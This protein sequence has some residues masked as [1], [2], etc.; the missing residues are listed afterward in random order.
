VSRSLPEFG[1]DQ[2]HFAP[3]IL[4]ESDEDD[5]RILKELHGDPRI[6]VIDRLAQQR[7][8]LARLHPAPATDLTDEP[9]RWA[10]YPWRRTAVRILGPR[11]YRTL[12]LDRNRNL[13]TVDE[14]ARLAALHVGVIGLSVGNVVAHTLAM[15]GLCGTVRLADF[16][17]LEL[18][19]LNRVPA[20]IL[21]VGVN[22]ATVAARR[23]TEL[24]PYL[25]VDVI[26]SG[27]TADSVN[28]FMEGLDLVVEECDSLDMKVVVR[29]AARAKRIPVLMSTSDRGLV[30]VERFD[31]EPD[32]PILH[33]L[34]RGVDSSQLAGL[35]SR[36]KIPHMLGFL[37]VPNM[38]PRAAASM[39]E[40]DVSLTTWPQLAGEVV[41]GATAVAAAV[42]RIGLG[43]PLASG[44]VRIDVAAALDD[45][46][47]PCARPDA[48]PRQETPVTANGGSHVAD[49]IV[50]AANRAPSAGNSQPWLI[51]WTDRSV[52]IRVNPAVTS[53]LDIGYRASAVAVGASAFN[54]KVAAAAHETL[55]P[56]EFDETDETSPLKATLRLGDHADPVLAR[57]YPAMLRRQTNRRSGNPVDID[58]DAAKSLE[59]V[60]D[61][62]GARL[63]LLTERDDIEKA[64]AILAATDRARFLTPQLHAEMVSEIR[65]PEDA[66][67][68]TGIEVGS[69]EYEPDE[70]AALDIL[71]RADVMAH[72]SDWDAGSSLGDNT[73][74]RVR[75]CAALGVIIAR[76]DTLRDYAR[77]GSAAE[78]VWIAAENQGL[79]VHPVSPLFLYARDDDELGGL[80]TQ[81]APMLAALRSEFLQLAAIAADESPIL[82]L[83]FTDA[84]RP[85]SRSR[86]RSLRCAALE[87]D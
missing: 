35:S 36:D 21:D 67:L 45:L 38:S 77:G 57:L 82:V 33:G 11:A 65:W 32:R 10:Y 84:P 25:S 5:L 37:D 70:L 56:V 62:E 53:K 41:L 66:D 75:A 22:K 39:I 31:L 3:T 9:C 81:F 18:S 12:R 8:N 26:P 20:S 42:R 61:R 29:E 85:S 30:D 13:I 74:D 16:D 7:E 87:L 79:A 54:A 50:A 51:D 71:R 40:V 19:N 23:I 69:L 6:E 86:R 80:S 2:A 44:R 34:L 43:Q 72:L 73:R 63:H 24:D 76:G 1:T 83:R 46:Q 4:D 55:G 15:E 64:A 28:E 78:A 58:G 52:T 59:G 17:I 49:N 68:D 47:N 14:Q 48:L 60:V 27:L